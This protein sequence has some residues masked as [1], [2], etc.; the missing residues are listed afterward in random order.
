MPTP[1]RRLVALLVSLTASLAVACGQAPASASASLTTGP[2]VTIEVR[3]GECPQGACGQTTVI[4]RDGRVHVTEPEPAEVATLP[5][6]LLE[7][8][9]AEVDQ[10]DFAALASRP[11]TGEC[12]T[13]FDGQEIV[14]TFVAPSGSHRL[15]SCEVEIDFGDPL[16]SVALEAAGSGAPPAP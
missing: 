14:F 2:L 6:P 1:Q 12:P 5:G 10:A 9:V 16:F 13:A 8:L 11:F 7:A 15:A 4:E 3:G